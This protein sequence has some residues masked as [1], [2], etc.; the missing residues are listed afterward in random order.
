[1][2]T[3]LGIAVAVATTL[4]VVAL[5]PSA[6][7]AASLPPEDM[8]AELEWRLPDGRHAIALR[9]P[10]PSWLTDELVAQARRGPTAVPLQAAPDVPA[11]GFVGIRPGSFMVDPSGCRMNFVFRSGGSYAIGTAGHCVDRVGQRVTL[12]TVAP[13]GGTPVLVDIG[14]VVVRSFSTKRIAPDFALVRIRPELNAWVFATIAQVG[15]PCVI[16]A[17]SGLAQVPVP[18]IFNGQASRAGP[19]VVAHY[20]HGLGVGTGGTARS[21]VAVYWESAAYYFDSAAAFGDSGS[22]VRV[23]D[24]MAAG[25]L[26]ALVVDSQHPGA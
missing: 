17:G 11:S 22:P 25:N 18:T 10:R 9:R 5:V 21:G 15:G 23:S 12:L 19:E 4:L 20:G 13:G 7:H 26:T 6:G 8:I 2:R 24:L 16:Y 1:M 14:E 3:R